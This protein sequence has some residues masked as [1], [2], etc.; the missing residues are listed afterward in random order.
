MKCSM[1]MEDLKSILN[2]DNYVY[3]HKTYILEYSKETRR[4]LEYSEIKLSHSYTE[5]HLYCRL[6]LK[7]HFIL[8]IH[9]CGV[10]YIYICTYT[11]TYAHWPHEEP[12][13]NSNLI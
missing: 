9:I 12:E 1:I 11:Y 8:L 6:F 10:L 4:L 2:N 7:F 5:N 13:N 3:V